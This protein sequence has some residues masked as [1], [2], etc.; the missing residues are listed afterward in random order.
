MANKKSDFV[1]H[2]TKPIF[3]KIIRDIRKIIR[4]I[5]RTMCRII[6]TS[7]MWQLMQRIFV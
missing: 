4:D 1:V 5:I 6:F 2:K 3:V 7:V